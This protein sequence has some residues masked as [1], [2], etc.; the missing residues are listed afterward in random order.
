MFWEKD[1][2]GDAYINFMI[3][4]STDSLHSQ[5]KIEKLQKNCEKNIDHVSLT[6]KE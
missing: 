1:R 4:M 3:L 2:V 6:V 5:S